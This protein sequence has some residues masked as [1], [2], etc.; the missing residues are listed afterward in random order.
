M[1]KRFGN[2]AIPVFCVNMLCMFTL[3]ALVEVAQAGELGGISVR[4]K[5]IVLEGDK[6]TGEVVL[7]NN[8]NREM[9]YRVFFKNLRMDKNGA[10]QEVAH[11]T[12]GEKFAAEFIRFAPRQITVPPRSS[13]SV[14]LL[15]RKPQGLKPGEYRSHLFFQ[16]LPPPTLGEDIERTTLASD[17]LKIRFVA[18]LA[19]SIP[20]IVRHGDLSAKVGLADLSLESTDSNEAPPLLS[21]KILRKGNR[22]VFGDISIFFKDK[23]GGRMKV[24]QV[25]GLSVYAPNASRHLK[26]P[27]NF[28]AGMRPERGS[29]HV[30]YRERREEGGTVLAKARIPVP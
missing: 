13:R 10:Y 21:A 4:P 5:R 6:R 1:K 25:G 3:C 18:V 19:I 8:S 26:I 28:P 2:A 9:T 22:S 15:A 11:G 17:E 20:V 27:L 24:G 7:H 23:Q 30:V 12:P 14:R 29:L 16:S